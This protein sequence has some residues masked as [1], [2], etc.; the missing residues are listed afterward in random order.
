MLKQDAIKHFGSQAAVGRVL[1]IGRAAVSK[2]PLTVPEGYAAIL[3]LRSGGK[4]PYD[5]AAYP[6]PSESVALSA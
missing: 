5:P 1:G 2:W 3:H 6:K 4:L